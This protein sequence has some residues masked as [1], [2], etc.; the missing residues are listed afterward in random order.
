MKKFLSRRQ[1]GEMLSPVISKEHEGSWK[2]YKNGKV[3]KELSP[4]EALKEAARMIAFAVREM[5]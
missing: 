1:V 5:K 4:L 2:T 3:I